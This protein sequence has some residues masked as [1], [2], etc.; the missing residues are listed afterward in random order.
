MAPYLLRFF[1][2]L[3]LV[4][5]YAAE[6]QDAPALTPMV[7]DPQRTL[8]N[9]IGRTFERPPRVYGFTVNK[10]IDPRLFL[11]GTPLDQRSR[12]SGNMLALETRDRKLIL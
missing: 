10:L 6:P 7:Y 4:S 3:V 2:L 11:C 8:I 9:S 1:P 5:A 12:D